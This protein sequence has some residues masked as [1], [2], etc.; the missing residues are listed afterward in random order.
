MDSIPELTQE[1]HTLAISGAFSRFKSLYV[2]VP[3]SFLAPLSGTAVFILNLTLI[4][5]LVLTFYLHLSLIVS[6]AQTG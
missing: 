6:G 4:S 5:F 1:S 3:S 2:F